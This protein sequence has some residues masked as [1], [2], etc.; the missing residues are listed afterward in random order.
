VTRDAAAAQTSARGRPPFPAVCQEDRAG[1]MNAVRHL[2]ELGHS[3]IAHV[4]GPL[5]FLHSLSRRAAL[6]DALDEAWVASPVEPV[7]GNESGASGAT[8]DASIV[9]S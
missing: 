4:A 8:S 9:F 2:V 5:T 7:R 1:V 6:A 3:R